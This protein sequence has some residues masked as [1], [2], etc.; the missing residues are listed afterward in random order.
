M[1]HPI[2]TTSLLI[3]AFLSLTSTTVNAS[4]SLA[5]KAGITGAGVDVSVPVHAKL[6]ARLGAQAVT[7]S[8]D[9]EEDDI[10]YEGDVKFNTLGAFLDWRPF[11]N[12]FFTTVGMLRNNN[13]IQFAT[14]TVG[15][16]SIEVG[17][18]TYSGDFEVIG[19]F[20]VANISPYIGF[21]WG[22]SPKKT[23]GLGFV[24]EF[25]VLYQGTMAFN[26]DATG[27]ASEEGST[28]TIDVSTDPEFQ[29][30]LAEEQE[31]FL[32]E[33]DLDE[34]KVLPVINIGLSYTF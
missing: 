9:I 3:A 31:N 34:L 27:T 22:H 7:Y 10:D 4:T 15:T 26:L 12:G 8:V 23:G 20:D 18:T 28:T 29:A 25:G 17:D 21:G 1:L 2:Q 33:T 13:T 24:F 14:G 30:A 32:E 6:S 11:A 19:G 16:E 5:A